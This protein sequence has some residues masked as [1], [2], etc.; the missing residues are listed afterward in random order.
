MK[1][2][3]LHSRRHVY[4][5]HTQHRVRNENVCLLGCN[6]VVRNVIVSVPGMRR[7]ARKKREIGKNECL[8]GIIR[9]SQPTPR[10][11]NSK[12]AIV[13]QGEKRDGF[14]RGSMVT[15]TSR[16][17][18]RNSRTRRS[19]PTTCDSSRGPSWEQEGNSQRRHQEFCDLWASRIPPQPQYFH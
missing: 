14:S 16:G 9:R 2:H 18:Y 8:D 13:L 7:P 6:I 15:N 5:Y 17:C 1:V 12:R 19:K 4:E 10:L 11:K 3:A